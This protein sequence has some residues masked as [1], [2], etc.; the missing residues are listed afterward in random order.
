MS[1]SSNQ[2]DDARPVIFGEVLFDRLPDGAVLGGAP[3]NV[4]WHLQGFGLRPLFVSRVGQDPEGDDVFMTMSDWGMDTAGVQRDPERPT[5]AVQVRLS[6]GQPS[7]NILPE[8]AYDYIDGVQAGAALAGEPLALLYLGTLA[9]RALISREA[10][11]ALRSQCELP[12]FVDI[13]L[14]APWWDDTILATVLRGARWV[15]LNDEELGAVLGRRLGHEAIAD[16]G[17]DLRA[18][19]DLDLLVVTLGADGAWFIT[20]EGRRFGEPAPVETLVDTVGAGD[21]FSAVTLLGLMRGWSLE[22]TLPRA[23][24][25]AARICAQRGATAANPELYQSFLESWGDG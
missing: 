12:T 16:A 11:V 25:F 20:P 13:N 22:T 5:G 19:H 9:N 3:F 17:E 24:A 21:A 8:Q 1:D 18:R 7:F 10:M 4:A 6:A 2:S 23:L 14:R 15:K